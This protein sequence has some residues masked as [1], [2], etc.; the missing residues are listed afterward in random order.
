MVK[1]GFYMKSLVGWFNWQIDHFMHELK[2]KVK[3]VFPSLI[4]F[5]LRVIFAH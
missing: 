5:L 2:Y 4:I 3:F 1:L